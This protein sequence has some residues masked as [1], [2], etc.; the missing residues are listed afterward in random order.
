MINEE[1]IN[2]AIEAMKQEMIEYLKS[3]NIAFKR[4][5]LATNQFYLGTARGYKKSLRLLGIE[6]YVVGEYNFANKMSYV[7]SILIDGIE[8]MMG[9]LEESCEICEVQND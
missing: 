5:D 8:T 7:K 4:R 6:A 1:L 3:A 2:V 9:D